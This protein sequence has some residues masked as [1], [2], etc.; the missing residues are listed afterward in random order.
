MNDFFSRWRCLWALGLIGLVPGRVAAQEGL[1]LATFS[2]DATPPIGTP[3]AYDEML[4]VDQPLSCRGVVLLGSGLPI[5]L[6][7]VDWI[8]IANGG[9]DAFKK[10]F[11]EAA[12]TL[13]S[14][15]S[16]H[17]V[18]QH[19]APLYDPTANQIL[20]PYGLSDVIVDSVFVRRTIAGAASAIQAA[21]AQARSVT[22]VGFAKAEVER[23]ASNRRILGPDG[24]VAQTRYTACRDPKLRA[25]PVGLVDP[26]VRLTSFW[27][28]NEALAVLSFFATHPQSYYRTG[29]ANPDF[30]GIA[31]ELRET[32]TGGVFQVHFNGAGGNVGAGKW[33]D[34]NKENRLLLA[35]RLA[36]GMKKAFEETEKVS[37]SVDDVDWVGE[38][39]DLPVAGHLD[40]AALVAQLSEESAS[41][42]DRKAA[43]RNLAWLRRNRND[44]VSS[45]V[46][47]LNLGPV[48]MLFCPGEMVVEYQLE[49]QRM[50]PGRF[51]CLAAYG[52]YGPGYICLTRHYDEGGYEASPRASRVAPSVEGVLMATLRR[53]LNQ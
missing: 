23:V 44:G 13:P 48:Q 35:I 25:M 16:V 50:R 45:T 15:V 36:R 47:G 19:D 10:A 53:V 32:E 40:E 8:G 33:N 52:D 17:T 11:A 22:H 38:A 39:I 12:A 28:G 1:R 4:W 49:A 26:F 46:N 18:H 21:M 14:R 3:L 37:I 42:L 2:V 9:Q 27:N 41:V 5:V 6:A 34:G 30:P 29:G 20:T 43:A 51:V 7:S 31:R 24:K